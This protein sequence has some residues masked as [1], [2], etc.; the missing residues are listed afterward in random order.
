MQDVEGGSMPAVD[1]GSCSA[2]LAPYVGMVF[3]TVEEAHEF[4]ND[5]AKQLGFGTRI[6]CSK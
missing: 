1:E 4:C 5:Y 2:P 6:A 3:K